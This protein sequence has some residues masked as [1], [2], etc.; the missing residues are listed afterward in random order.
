MITFQKLKKSEMV[1]DVPPKFT[2]YLTEIQGF[3]NYFFEWGS[4]VNSAQVY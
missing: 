4:F 2:K 1:I 3:K